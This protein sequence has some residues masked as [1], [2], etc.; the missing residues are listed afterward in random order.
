MKL[1]MFCEIDHSIPQPVRLQRDL[2]L[3]YLAGSR[4]ALLREV[5]IWRAFLGRVPALKMMRAA[6][7]EQTPKERALNA[8]RRQRKRRH[9]ELNP[10]LRA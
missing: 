6:R 9:F 1:G 2:D 4:F 3:A 10:H 7:A 8:L 5:R